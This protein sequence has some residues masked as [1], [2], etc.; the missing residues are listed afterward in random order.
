[1]NPFR[2][3]IKAVL[4]RTLPAH[5]LLVRG[6]SKPQTNAAELATQQPARTVELSLTFD[7]GPH[8]EHTG[9]LLDYLAACEIHATF[10]VVGQL[11]RQHPRLVRRIV[12]E[13]HELG[14]HT[15]THGKP[16]ATSANQ[17]L[18]E[19]R[20]TRAL[21]QDLTGRDCKLVRPP[22]GKLTLGKFWGLMREELTIV[23]WNVD[24]R[25]Y[26]MRSKREMERWCE[27]YVPAD[28]DILLMHDNH[29]FS[30]AAV[31]MFPN[32]PVLEDVRFVRVSEWLSAEP[33][34]AGQRPSGEPVAQ[35]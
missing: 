9:R 35:V 15:F 22:L 28:G 34:V 32:L 6:P 4:S 31:A 10:F 30:G 33:C 26:A 8:H 13:G 2:Q 7:D 21:L 14:N 1:M 29:E 25:D 18:K 17:F 5:Q 3:I 27:S 24:P 16:S 11:A 12:N 19:I 23:L 20:Q